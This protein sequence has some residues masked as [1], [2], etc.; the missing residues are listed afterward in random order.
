MSGKPLKKKAKW[1]RVAVTQA[2]LPLIYELSDRPLE[3]GLWCLCVSKE[4][5][6]TE[7]LSFA[8]L[9]EI[10]KEF[11]DLPISALQLKR[12]FA[13]AGK[14]VIR[15]SSSR[16]I[17]IS[18]PGESY[19]RSLRK[20]EPLN[21]VYVSPNKPRTATKTLESLVKSLHKGTLLITDP[22]YGVKTFEVLETFAKHH[23]QI[24]FLTAKIGSGE[25]QAMVARVA[26]DFRK[27]FGKKVEIKLTSSKELHD[28]YI[29]ADGIFFV[30]G[31]GIKDLGHKESFIFGIEDR[32]GKDIRRTLER[33]FSQRWAKATPIT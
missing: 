19:L 3:A 25:K 9:E 29:I 12:A 17:K 32:Y 1:K 18:Q 4:T 28:R 10:L 26:K 20:Y 6:G 30:V 23:K 5:F 16:E 2:N 22:Y 15:N 8:G 33:V 14:N 11:L 7:Y 13:R 21:V 31:H 24:R 27:E